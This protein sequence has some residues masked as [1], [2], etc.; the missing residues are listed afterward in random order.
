MVVQ[1]NPKYNF[2][3][4]DTSQEYVTNY[5]AKIFDRIVIEKGMS[6]SI[7]EVVC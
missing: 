5:I 2:A 4:I 3:S 1:V 7:I 6:E